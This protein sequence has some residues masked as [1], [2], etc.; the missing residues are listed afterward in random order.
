MVIG[1]GPG[2]L[3]GP[4]RAH[5]ARSAA[6]FTTVSLACGLAVDAGQLIGFRLAQGVAAAVMIPKRPWFQVVSPRW[7][8]LQWLSC[9]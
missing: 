8:S 4:G 6:V 9:S 5:P 1:A 3:L 7:L 2:G